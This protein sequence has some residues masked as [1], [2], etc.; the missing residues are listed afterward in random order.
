MLGVVRL[1]LKQHAPE[2][3]AEEQ[4]VAI[5]MGMLALY[6][7]AVVFATIL[8]TRAPSLVATLPAVILAIVIFRSSGR[9]AR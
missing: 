2:Q 1:L 6:F 7:A 5:L 8:S 9:A 3:K 4:H